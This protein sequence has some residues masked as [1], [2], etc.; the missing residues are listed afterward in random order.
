M[1]SRRYNI[2]PTK[3]KV[4]VMTGGVK[5][6][7]SQVQL[8]IGELIRGVNY[9]EVDGIYNGYMSLSGYEAT[10]GTAL[11]SSVV[12]PILEDKGI[13]RFTTLLIEGVN[14]TLEDFS[15]EQ[16]ILTSTNIIEVANTKYTLDIPNSWYFGPSSSVSFASKNFDTEEFCIEAVINLS[17]LAADSYI[18]K[19]GTDILFYVEATSGDIRLKLNNLDKNHSF[20]QAL[21]INTYYHLSIRRIEDTIWL[22]VNGT[23]APDELILAAGYDILNATATAEID[24]LGYLAQYRISEGTH[25]R[26]LAAFEILD[27]PMS[28]AEYEITQFDDVAREA[29]RSAIDSIGDLNCTGD[30]LGGYKF[31]SVIYAARNDNTETY[32]T[33]WKTT[34]TGWSQLSESVLLRFSSGTLNAGTEFVIGET[35][36]GDDSSATGVILYINQ[37]GGSWSLGTASGTI[38][39]ASSAGT[40]NDQDVLSNTAGATAACNP[41]INVLK[42]DGKY[43]FI[44]GAF[45]LFSGLQ[46]QNVLFF[47][48][49]NSYPCYINSNKIIPIIHY[50]LPDNYTSGNFASAIVEFKNRLWLGYPDGRLVFSNVGDPVDFDST[51]FS[52]TI[53]L[54][55]EILD[56]IV[57]KGDSLFVFCRNSIQVIKALS[58]ST[59]D[60]QTIVDYLFSNSTLINDT[61]IKENTAVRLFDDILYV[62]DRG[63]T[64]ISATDTFGDFSTKAYSKAVQ[65]TLSAN[66]DNIVGAI[67]NRDYNQYRLFFRDGTGLIFTFDMRSI[68]NSMTTIVK[69]AT[70]FKYLESVSFVSER[71]FGCTTGFIYLIDS[72]TSFNGDAI[73]HLMSTSFYSYNSPGILKYFKEVFFE[74]L[75][76]YDIEFT[77]KPSFD[78]KNSTYTPPTSEENLMVMGG[79]GGTYGEGS[80]GTIKYGSSENQTSVFYINGYGSNLSFNLSSLSKY[81]EPHLLSAIIVQYSINGRKM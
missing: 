7:K 47:T 11:A 46:R 67:V 6:N 48:S 77:I 3:T 58:T 75:I 79:L 2:I 76:P 10:D 4:G 68:S 28:S 15:N 53:Y 23:E 45:D 13:D 22:E 70:F 81:A 19:S 61:E 35:I 62:D 52:G 32:G 29:R 74:G 72:G 80:Y 21:S 27:V 12:V 49:K 43:K 60:T 33:M 26:M 17:S 1:R 5:E 42:K 64:S 55:D 18:Y 30:A 8:N 57:G 40:F 66:F 69:G 65:R 78:Y 44:E 38:V 16:V 14:P 41:D 59:A 36:T 34:D 71:I 24:I 20:A 9:Q 50:D 73:N 54:E 63:L 39:L 25:R 51:T 31:G 37:E 56:L